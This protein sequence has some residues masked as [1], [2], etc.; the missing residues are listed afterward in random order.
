MAELTLENLRVTYP[1][2]GAQ[3]LDI[4]HLSI[5]SGE[6]VAITGPSGSGK[7]TLLNMLTGLE[8]PD[9]GLVRWDGEVISALPEAG[10]D[11]WRARHI[12]LVMQDFHLFSGLSALENVLLPA[13]FHTLRL[14]AETRGRAR[15]LL[16]RVGLHKHDQSVETMSRGEMQRV[17]VARA[18]LARPDILI[19]DEPTAS[20]DEASGAVVADLLLELAREAGATLIA[21]THDLRLAARM[22]RQLR[23]TGGTLEDITPAAPASPPVHSQMPE[24]P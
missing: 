19:A 16:E 7:T 5:A 24:M 14:P 9:E 13:R 22:D 3:V 17:A 23:L 2:L 1:G 18:L 8:Q 6:R 15:A 10:R 11:R 20:L 12:G 21:V 4:A